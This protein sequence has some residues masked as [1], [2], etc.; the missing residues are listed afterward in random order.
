MQNLAWDNSLESGIVEIDIQHRNLFNIFKVLKDAIENGK[1]SRVIKYI[2]DEIERYAEYHM[3]A[4]RG[5]FSKYKEK[6]ISTKDRILAREICEYLYAHVTNHIMKTDM[7][8]LNL[9]K[10]EFKRLGKGE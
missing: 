2:I 1:S 3:S 6:Y 8:E 10:A 4:E 9:L 5:I 7:E